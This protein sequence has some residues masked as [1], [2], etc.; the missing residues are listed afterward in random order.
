MA[1]K[2][3]SNAS[4]LEMEMAWFTEV[5]ETRLNLYFGKKEKNEILQFPAPPDLSGSE[6]YYARFVSSRNLTIPERLT[7]IL[8]LIPHIRPQL[9][10]VLWTQNTT[11]SRGFTEFGGWKG[12]HHS[13][14]I[15]TGE[16]AAFIIGGDALETRFEVTR[17]F[18]GTHPFSKQNILSLSTVAPGEPVLS[19]ALTVSGEYLNWFL[20][21]IERKPN[22][23]MEFPAKLIET[24]LDWDQ[25]VLPAYTLEQLEEIKHW[26]LHGKT[27][28]QEWEM[29][30]KLKPGYTS[31]FYGQPGTGKTFSACLLGKH[32]NCDVYRIDLS[33]IVSKYIGET[34][35][36]LSRIFD[37][38]EHKNWILF[39]DEA[40][41]LFGKRTKVEDA[42]DRYANQEVSYLL[43]RIEDFNGVVILASNLKTNIDQAFLRRFQSVIHFPMPK[44]AERLKIWK[45]AFSPKSVLDKKVD[46]EHLSEQYDISGG[47]IMN[48]VRFASLKALSRNTNTLLNDD[49]EEG[50]RREFLKE[51]KSI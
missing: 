7:L 44:P 6:S 1:D 17:I 20:M 35:K 19:G 24:R 31:L 36:N 28:L 49:L 2:L 4:D 18:E 22:Y 3:T 9:L 50:I 26:I 27:L 33:M 41:A 30:Q 16:T 47:T 37:M 39:F 11:T 15:P 51:G 42:H 48:V 14:F 29:D 34:E 43:Q 45:H 25:L 46:L 23:N 12:I 8:S 38:A 5:L 13:G 10:D 40:D 32:C 21:G